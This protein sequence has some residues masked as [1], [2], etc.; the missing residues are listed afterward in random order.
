MRPFT[1]KKNCCMIYCTSIV[2]SHSST[3][4]DSSSYQGPDL[5]QTAQEL[6]ST[7]SS[8]NRWFHHYW[9]PIYVGIRYT[10]VLYTAVPQKI[11]EFL[12]SLDLPVRIRCSAPTGIIYD[13]CR[14][15]SHLRYAISGRHTT[16]RQNT[17]LTKISHR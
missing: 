12:T 15:F 16:G 5:S 9:V 11:I 14:S 3:G 4:D 1:K 10:A 17:R 6:R 2:T 8:P 13:V 7:R